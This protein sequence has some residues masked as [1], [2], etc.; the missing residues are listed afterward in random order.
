MRFPSRGR[1]SLPI[2]A[3]TL[4]AG[5]LLA[6]GPTPAQATGV[7]LATRAPAPGVG[8]AATADRATSPRQAGSAGLSGQR[9]S[10]SLPARP[11]RSPGWRTVA[12]L[13]PDGGGWTTDIAVAGRADAWAVGVAFGPGPTP[14]VEHWNGS[15]WRAVSLP[16]AVVHPRFPTFLDTVVAEPGDVWA[17]GAAGKWLHW[18]GRKWTTGQVPRDFAALDSSAMFGPRDVWAFGAI[19]PGPGGAVPYAIRRTSSGG[20]QRTEV[21]GSNG[22]TAVSAISRNDIWAVLGAPKSIAWSGSGGGLVHWDGRRWHT[23]TSLPAALA[24]SSL[25]AVLARSDTNVWVGGATRTGKGGSTEAIGH[26]NG[27]RWSVVTLR[28]PATSA[29]YTVSNLVGD[30]A[31]GIWATGRCARCQVVSSRLWHE[32]AGRWSGPIVPRL[33]RFPWIILS[34]TATAHSVWADGAIDGPSPGVGGLI[35]LWGPRP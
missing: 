2:G 4:A 22:I 12:V 23:V 33:S 17:F 15:V 18:N 29:K 7:G 35:A 8:R 20:W 10:R 6:A 31:G 26:W 11:A 27:R 30:G 1:V 5:L 13:S 19:T 14:L 34:L 3:L 25:G 28:A 21:P 24:N 32:S 9:P 16:S